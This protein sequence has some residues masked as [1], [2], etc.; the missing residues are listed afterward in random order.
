M[1]LCQRSICRHQ[2]FTIAENYIAMLYRSR[3]QFGDGAADRLSFMATDT[4]RYTL[5]RGMQ[6]ITVRTRWLHHLSLDE[7]Q[8]WIMEAMCADAGLATARHLVI[9][10]RVAFVT[11]MKQHPSWLVTED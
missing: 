7:C 8:L 11:W 9:R 5:A 1:P 6:P 10:T 2:Y 3:V 4:T